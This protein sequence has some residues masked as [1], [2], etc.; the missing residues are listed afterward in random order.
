MVELKPF[1]MGNAET[2]FKWNND[3]EL[4]Y[5]DSDF[6]HEY[7]SYESFVNRLEKVVETPNATSQLY[8]IHL[9]D[10]PKLI[11]I[12]DIYRIDHYNSHCE[13][14][15]SIGDKDYRKKGYGKAALREAIAICFDELEVRKVYTKAFDFNKGWIKLVQKLGFVHEGTL[16]KHTRKDDGFS[17]KLIFGLLAEEYTSV[18]KN[19]LAEALV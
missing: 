15:C 9:V 2:H 4:N 18:Q 10:E 19:K 5:Y 14:E 6:P 1:D 11:G 17:D 13:L 12:V 16:R 8:E 7:E 3:E